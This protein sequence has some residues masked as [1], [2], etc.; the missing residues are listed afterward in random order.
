MDCEDLDGFTKKLDQIRSKGL[1]SPFKE[2]LKQTEIKV[3]R[4]SSKAVIYVKYQYT[5]KSTSLE[6]QKAHDI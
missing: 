5:Q 1:G 6:V 3:G 2:V 4:V